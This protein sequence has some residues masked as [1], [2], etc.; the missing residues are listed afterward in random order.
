MEILQELIT[1]LIKIQFT[2]MPAPMMKMMMM[3]FRSILKNEKR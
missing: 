2:V 3:L 1:I